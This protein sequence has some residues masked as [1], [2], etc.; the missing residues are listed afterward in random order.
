MKSL[1]WLSAKLMA[2]AS[3]IATSPLRDGIA[4]EPARC[5]CR[6]LDGSSISWTSRSCRCCCSSTSSSLSLPHR[7]QMIFKQKRQQTRTAMRR[8]RKGM[9]E[10][11]FEFGRCSGEVGT[12]HRAPTPTPQL[13]MEVTTDVATKMARKLDEANGR[14]ILYSHRWGWK[15]G[16]IW[17]HCV[18]NNETEC[19]WIET[20]TRLRD[21]VDVNTRKLKK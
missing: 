3:A 11:F 9:L 4:V 13:P 7:L 16:S 10:L 17:S 20:T 2:S 8:R 5:C 12:F 21:T 15:L 1:L 19:I 18:F 6:C 14:I